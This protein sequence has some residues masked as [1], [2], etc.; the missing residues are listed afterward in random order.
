MGLYNILAET[1]LFQRFDDWLNSVF[2]FD[3]SF[4]SFVDWFLSYPTII[5]IP[6]IIFV[7]FVLYLGLFQLIK[8]II[9]GLPK[10]VLFLIIFIIIVYFV[11]AYFISK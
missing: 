3:E 7:L 5:K 11:L 2:S 10:K 4:Q 6:V 9:F 1:N 8:K